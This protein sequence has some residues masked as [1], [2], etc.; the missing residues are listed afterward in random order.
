MSARVPVTRRHARLR[1]RLRVVRGAERPR[2]GWQPVD[3]AAAWLSV[4]VPGAGQLYRRRWRPALRH[5]S[6]A[7]VCLAAAVQLPA[8]RG[9]ALA[10]V[11]A[12]GL[13][14]AADAARFTPPPRLRRL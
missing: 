14:S 1:A 13:W 11:A 5:A 8:W 2:P 3:G 9:V 4:L 10:L 6:L 12:V 7:A